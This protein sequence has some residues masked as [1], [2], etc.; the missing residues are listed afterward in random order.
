TSDVFVGD[1]RFQMQ[2]PVLQ[3][4]TIRVPS[5]LTMSISGGRQVSGDVSTN[6]LGFS[7]VTDVTVLNG[8]TWTSTYNANLRTHTLT[9]PAGRTRSTQL[10][11]LGRVAQ[12]AIPGITS[13]VFGYDASG[14]LATSSQG[15]RAWSFVYDGAGRL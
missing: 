4:R 5:G 10:N 3:S 8:H 15:N 7:S 2:A 6:P 12:V 14:N 1:P 11:A 13:V 9:T